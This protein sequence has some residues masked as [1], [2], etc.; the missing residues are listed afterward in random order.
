MA[1]VV[2]R[3]LHTT[4]LLSLLFFP[5]ISG[6]GVILLLPYPKKRKMKGFVPPSA[7]TSGSIQ[8]PLIAMKFLQCPFRR[9]DLAFPFLAL[10]RE[11]R[12][13]EMHHRE[14]QQPAWPESLAITPARRVQTLGVLGFCLRSFTLLY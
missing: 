10:P 14:K 12:E 8:K 9:G 2:A 6:S 5:N 3:Y 11:C 13:A 7:E 4:D 1:A